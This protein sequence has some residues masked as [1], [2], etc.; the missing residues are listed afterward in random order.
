MAGRA[1]VEQRSG[2]L[3]REDIEAARLRGVVN[4]LDAARRAL[5]GGDWRSHVNNGREG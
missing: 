3:T 4:G 1:P 5:L 2:S